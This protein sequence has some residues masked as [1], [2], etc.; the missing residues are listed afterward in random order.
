[1]EQITIEV[2]K[3]TYP[4]AK[5]ARRAGQIPIIYYGKGTA[6]VQFTT[7]Y[8]DFRRAYRKAGKSAILTLND[9]KEEYQALVHEVQYEPIS[10]D[11]MH[12]DLMAV[13]K[14]QKIHTTVPLVFVGESSAVREQGGTFT[15][16]KDSVS[17]ECLPADLP[18]EIEVDITSLIDFHTSLTV[19]DIKAPEGVVITDAKDISIATVSA[20]QAEEVETPVAPAEGE[21]I[22]TEGEESD[23]EK[24]EE[25]KE[26]EEA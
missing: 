2:Q 22:K 14:G 18:H 5:E 9:G 17:I 4:S 8:Q 20:P 21:E 13:K 24:K 6:P 19:G 12:V 11:I 26:K 1:M 23:E 25:E 3:G 15:S 16:G 7:E 10:D